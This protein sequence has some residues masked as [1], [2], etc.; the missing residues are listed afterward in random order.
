MFDNIKFGALEEV[1]FEILGFFDSVIGWLDYTVG[2]AESP[3]EY[4]KTLQKLFFPDKFTDA[5]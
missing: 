4:E 5:E 1:V 3:Y 2:G